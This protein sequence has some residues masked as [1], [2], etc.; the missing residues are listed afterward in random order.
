MQIKIFPFQLRSFPQN[1]HFTTKL[2]RAAFFGTLLDCHWLYSTFGFTRRFPIVIRS[3][4]GSRTNVQHGEICAAV[5]GN[6]SHS[7]G[8]IP[9]RRPF[10][11]ANMLVLWYESFI[12]LLWLL[13]SSSDAISSLKTHCVLNT[14]R[15]QR[16][17][18]YKVTPKINIFAGFPQF[19]PQFIERS[20]YFP[21]LCIL[22]IALLNKGK[23]LIVYTR[24]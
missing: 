20:R 24:L 15:L 4:E 2:G 13:F 23:N 6:H 3:V 21:L 14:V 7:G 9:W 11:A 10:A 18:S 19:F 17:Q 16:Q 12:L 1:R 8:F 5:F 22:R